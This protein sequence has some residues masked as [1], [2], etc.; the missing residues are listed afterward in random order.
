[1]PERLHVFPVR[2][3]LADGRAAASVLVPADG[4]L[5]LELAL[6]EYLDVFHTRS[7][8]CGDFWNERSWP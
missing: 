2:R 6:L 4:P 1:M 8:G 7:E 5:D 3:G